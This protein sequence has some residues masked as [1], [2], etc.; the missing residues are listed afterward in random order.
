MLENYIVVC[1]NLPYKING[2]IMYD[3]A[4]DY[5]T[6]VLNSRSGYYK[7]RETF[8]HEIEH[9]LNGDFH[10]NRNVGLLEAVLH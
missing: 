6:I 8:N 9:I 1:E 3:A 2:F 7:N 5:Y 4:D 10:K